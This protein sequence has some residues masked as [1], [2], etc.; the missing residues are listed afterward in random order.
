MISEL[1]NH[2]DMTRRVTFTLLMISALLSESACADKQQ[3]E[4]ESEPETVFNASAADAGTRTVLGDRTDGGYHVLWAEGDCIA[5]NGIVSKPLDAENSGRNFAEFTVAE[6][7]A[8]PYTAIYPASAVAGDS[9]VWIPSSQSPAETGFDASAAVM[10]AYGESQE[11]S[12]RQTC[13]YLR[14]RVNYPDGCRRKAARAVFSGNGSETVAG[15]FGFSIDNGTPSLGAASGEGEKSIFITSG[16]PGSYLTDFCISMPALTFQEG[17]SIEFYDADGAFLKAA[18]SAK[19]TLKTGVILNAPE[20]TFSMIG[21]TAPGLEEIDGEH[22]NIV[23]GQP[24]LVSGWCSAYGRAHRLNDGRLMICYSDT[25]NAKA[26]FSSDNGAT[27]SAQKV[28]VK[29]YKSDGLTYKMDNPEFAQ[30]SANNPYHPGR[31]IYAVNE[32]VKDAD[33]NNAYPFHISVCTSDDNGATWSSLGKIYSSNNVSGCY[34]PFVLELPDGT[35]QVYFADET[36]Y[37]SYQ[38]ISVIESKDGGDTWGTKRIV[39]YTYAKRDGMPTATIYDGNI[40]VAIEAVWDNY[41]FCPQIVYNPVSGS[42]S[43]MV[44]ENSDYRFNPFLTP[45]ESTEIYFG[46][47]YLIQTDNYFVLSYQTTKGAPQSTH[48]ERYKHTA[49][50]VQLCPKSEVSQA[51]FTTMRS[52]TR[53]FAFD[54]KV[55][56]AKWNSL[57][58]LGGDE[59]LAVY[60]S[61][62]KDHEGDTGYLYVVR[63]RITTSTIDLK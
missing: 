60:G 26:R 42:W 61:G 59:I 46:A 44:R 4:T 10:I 2:I 58:P 41:R 56:C 51:K 3:T 7:V 55:A 5:V 48:E 15:N 33:N 34:E 38:N 31:I 29:T 47:P 35:V 18:T 9:S 13:A 24:V 14:I 49:M 11:L 6:K 37:A 1:K 22:P 8:S 28:V 40:Y 19:V 25:W 12:F 17:F 50:E 39:C 57:C 27:W 62:G 20:L 32:R 36:P 52:A 45:M 16:T 43:S 63:G 21:G 23:W 53:P 54:Q 30:L